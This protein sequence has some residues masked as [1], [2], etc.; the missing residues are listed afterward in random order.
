MSESRAPARPLTGGG[1]PGRSDPARPAPVGVSTQAGGERRGVP[2]LRQRLPDQFGLAAVGR[3][4]RRRRSRSRLVGN[5][6]PSADAATTFAAR[7]AR[8]GGLAPAAPGR[9]PRTSAA[10][11]TLS[12][13]RPNAEDTCSRLAM[14]RTSAERFVPAPWNSAGL[15]N[16]AS[17]LRERQLDVVRLEVGLEFRQVATRGSRARTSASAA[18][19]SSGRSR[20]GMSQCATAPCRV[21]TGDRRCTCAGKRAIGP[22]V[23]EARGGSRGAD[24]APAPP[25]LTTLTCE[26]TW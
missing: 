19:T 16:A 6:Y 12:I 18:G 24:S 7:L 10:R 22:G 25:G 1:R 9:A 5:A 4:R 20:R 3:G 23:H 2:A 15:K 14:R 17:P 26:V 11:S 21:S 13:A 8:A